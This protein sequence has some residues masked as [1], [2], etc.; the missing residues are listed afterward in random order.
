MDVILNCFHLSC[1]LKKFPSSVNLHVEYAVWRWKRL[2]TTVSDE[3][4]SN[5]MPL[6]IHGVYNAES[7]NTR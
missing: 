5:E 7:L 6:I 4:R 1:I 2:Q 3:E